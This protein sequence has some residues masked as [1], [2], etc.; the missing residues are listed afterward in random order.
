MSQRRPS[1]TTRNFCTKRLNDVFRL[2]DGIPSL[3]SPMFLSLAV[4][5]QTD[6]TPCSTFTRIK[7]FLANIKITGKTFSFSQ[8]IVLGVF[9][10][11]K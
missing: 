6:E 2:N 8:Y 7:V 5:W 9:D 4:V 3:R 1:Y 11:G 10:N